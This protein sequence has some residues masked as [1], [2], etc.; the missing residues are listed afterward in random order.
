MNMNIKH[1]KT[2]LSSWKN[3][4]I[5]DKDN[6]MITFL[7]ISKQDGMNSTHARKEGHNFKMQYTYKKN[8]TKRKLRVFLS[9]YYTE[10]FANL[11]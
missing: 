3:L 6:L 10:E 7:I 2:M 4:Y 5:S 8:N 1:L 9:L 11:L